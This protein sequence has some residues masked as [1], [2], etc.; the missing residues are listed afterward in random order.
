MEQLYGTKFLQENITKSY[1]NLKPNFKP[2]R[3]FEPLRLRLDASKEFIAYD[4]IYS[5]FDSF[6]VKPL[7][8]KLLELPEY[9][10]EVCFEFGIEIISI[11][12]KEIFD[13]RVSYR[14]KRIIIQPE[15]FYDMHSAGCYEPGARLV[16]IH[17]RYINNKDYNPLAYFIAKGFQHAIL[18]NQNILKIQEYHISYQN[19]YLPYYVIRYAF[20]KNPLY[21]PYAL[22][23]FIN[24]D[25]YNIIK[26]E[27]R[28]LF[29]FL[30]MLFGKH[31]STIEWEKQTGQVVNLFD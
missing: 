28:P 21:F 30:E 29:R 12:N 26:S 14:D 11:G 22:E 9:L 1:L 16:A 20:Q 4:Q 10:L 3:L 19:K 8:N 15:D 27:D 2:L 23:S 24:K 17:N 31:Q 25:R 5:Y 13:K 6:E 7:K 18:S